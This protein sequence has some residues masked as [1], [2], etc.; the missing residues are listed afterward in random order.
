MN[1]A[2]FVTPH[3]SPAVPVTE[4]SDWQFVPAS[5]ITTGW[6]AERLQA[7]MRARKVWSADL[8]GDCQN[9]FAEL[10]HF[11][12]YYEL[13]VQLRDQRR[14]QA[15][16]GKLLHR[17]AMKIV[18]VLHAEPSLQTSFMHYWRSEKP[19]AALQSAQV[20]AS[21]AASHPFSQGD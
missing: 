9:W 13:Y 6:S 7:E 12:A 21:A 16:T 11:G 10:V 5:T 3:Q 1:T 14:E 20:D 4:D 19:Q 15:R 17:D 2:S 18:E 8:A